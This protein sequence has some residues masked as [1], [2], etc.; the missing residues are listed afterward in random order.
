MQHTTQASIAVT[1]G[2]FGYHCAVNS[3]NFKYSKTVHGSQLF[4]SPSSHQ[5]IEAIV[6]SLENI[7]KFASDCTSARI[8]F[9]DKSVREMFERMSFGKVSSSQLNRYRRALK[10]IKV[11]F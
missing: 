10:T 1:S 6:D 9:K 8:I 3:E 7:Q 11:V 2:A 5:A 4:A